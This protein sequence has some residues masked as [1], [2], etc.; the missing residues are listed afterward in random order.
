MPLLL[1]NEKSEES[2]SVAAS[3]YSSCASSTT[4]KGIEMLWRITYVR[5]G[6]PRGVTFAKSDMIAALEFAELWEEMTR[7]PVLTLKQ[8]R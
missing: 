1:S 2:C 3:R 8:V 7:C 6:R 5:D 4:Q